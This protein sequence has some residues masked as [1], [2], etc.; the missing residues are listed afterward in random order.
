MYTVNIYTVINK[1]YCYLYLQIVAKTGKMYH[2]ILNYNN[3]IIFVIFQI[4]VSSII[5]IINFESMLSL[6]FLSQVFE[7]VKEF[8]KL[9]FII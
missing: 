4:E 5:F 7:S 1:Y 3:I 9:C 2:Y 6:Y 8:H